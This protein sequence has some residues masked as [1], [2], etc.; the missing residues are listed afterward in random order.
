MRWASQFALLVFSGGLLVL[1]PAQAQDADRYRRIPTEDGFLEVE[2]ATGAVRECRR[3][4]EGY[5][6]SAP[7]ADKL[8]GELERLTRE[9]L[10]LRQRL[11]PNPG[12]PKPPPDE[13]I[14]RALSVME[15]FLRRFMNILREERPDR[16]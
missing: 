10:E 16:T 13:E 1:G 4:A 8:Q 5:R 2:T 3:T 15:R 6:C 14:D 9:N 7:S 12:S 11:G